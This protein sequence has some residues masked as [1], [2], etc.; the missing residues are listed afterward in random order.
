MLDFAPVDY[1]AITGY[2]WYFIQLGHHLR[3]EVILYI[4]GVKMH[5]TV[6]SSYSAHV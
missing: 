2:L 1:Q 3:S 5:L 6:L 4:R